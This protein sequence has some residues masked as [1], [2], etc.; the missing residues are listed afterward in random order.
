M[1]L[2]HPIRLQ[3]VRPDLAAPCNVEL[4][5]LDR[6]RFR[7]LFLQFVLEQPRT[8][9]LHADFFVLVLRSLV[10]T[11]DDNVGRQMCNTYRRVGG[12]HVLATLSARTIRVDSELVLVDF[13]FNRIVDLGIHRNGS[14]R[15]MPPLRSIEWRNTDEPVDPSF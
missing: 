7:L 8:Q 14:K 11:L 15:R 3:H 12:V 10:L 4:A 2:H 6:L 1:V 5:V 13:D 9:H